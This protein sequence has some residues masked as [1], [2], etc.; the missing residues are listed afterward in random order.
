MD[1]RGSLVVSFNGA[2]NVGKSTQIS[3]LP[4][5]FSIKRFGGL[6]DGDEK[7][8]KLV[9]SKALKDWWWTSSDAESVATIFGA[10][11][12]RHESAK[13][14]GFAL[15][16]L[17]WGATMFEA[18]S[19]AT[20][21]T[22]RAHTETS[23]ARRLYTSILTELNIQVPGD[24][25]AIL[26]K[27]DDGLKAPVQKSLEREPEPSDDRYRAYQ[28]LLHEELKH[29]EESSRYQH[30]IPDRGSM[31]DVQDR[32]RLVLSPQV[33]RILRPSFTPILWGISHV[34]AFG[35]LSECGKSTLAQDFCCK[36]VPFVLHVA[37]FACAD[38]IARRFLA[39]P[40]DSRSATSVVRRAHDWGDQFMSCLK[41]TRR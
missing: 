13:D 33:A 11:Q 5:H 1:R 14:S 23:V 19:I 6:H 40:T 35:G 20:I 2:D 9:K 18:V 26:L 15:S 30:V 16:V 3:L 38:R 7:L 28:A 17:D 39:R 27:L 24:E 10:V 41:R 22:K 34:V 36:Q 31:K 12:H 8:A 4:P 32:I 25:I 29:Q 21:A 37:V